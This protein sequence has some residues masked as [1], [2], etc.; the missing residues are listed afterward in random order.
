MTRR[1]WSFSPGCVC[2]GCHSGLDL[3]PSRYPPQRTGVSMS[4]AG[5]VDDSSYAPPPEACG[6]VRITDLKSSD[7]VDLLIIPRSGRCSVR[8]CPGPTVAAVR[9]SPS[10][11]RPGYWQLYCT[12]HAYERGVDTHEGRLDWVDGFPVTGGSRILLR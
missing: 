12:Q 3:T 7:P 4:A 6:W 11:T 2:S 10:R 5:S 1:G 8:L 9:R